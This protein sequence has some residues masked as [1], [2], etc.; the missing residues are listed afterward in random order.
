MNLN[1]HQLFVKT[2]ELKTSQKKIQINDI[3]FSFQKETLD[4]R[5]QK[6]IACD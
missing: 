4:E 5:N 3:F 6:K 1:N 2:E